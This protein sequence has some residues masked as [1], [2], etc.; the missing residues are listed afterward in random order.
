[1]RRMIVNVVV[2]LAVSGATPVHA[3]APKAE[4]KR[5]EVLVLGVYHMG[6]RDATSTT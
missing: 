1:M 6:I 4:A 3:A 2:M 5:A